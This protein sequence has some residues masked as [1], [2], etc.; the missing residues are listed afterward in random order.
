MLKTFPQ[1]DV[2]VFGHTHEPVN[3]E[4]D[5]KLLLNPGSTTYPWPRGSP[6]TIALLHLEL[7]KEPRA[8]II[9]LI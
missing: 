3:Q 5:G 1:A 4:V 7:K 2:I 9:R 6:G 8:E